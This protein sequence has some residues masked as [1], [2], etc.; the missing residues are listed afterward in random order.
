[1]ASFRAPSQSKHRPPSVLV[2]VRRT[3]SDEGGNEIHA[4]IIRNRRRE[5]LDLRRSTND[6]QT[7]PQPLDYSSANENAALQGVLNSVSH[8]PRHGGHEPVCCRDRNRSRILQREASRPICIFRK[9]RR[10]ASLPK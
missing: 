8:F 6:S 9:S 10:S 7:I 3:Q 4:T 2:P 1:M 5:R